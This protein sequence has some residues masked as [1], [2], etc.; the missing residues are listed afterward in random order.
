[1]VTKKKTPKKTAK[2]EPIKK[3]DNAIN[4]IDVVF[5]LDATGSM[6]PYIEEAKRMITDITNK[7]IRENPDL[8]IRV[9]LVL[10]RDHP[11]QEYSFVTQV[12][13]F[14]NPAEFDALIRPVFASGGGDHPE[15]V[16]DGVD[17]AFG[18]SWREGADRAA[19]LIG[20]APPHKQCLCGITPEALIE[21]LWEMS[22]EV[23]AHSI[24]NH[25]ATTEAFKLLTD[26]TGGNLTTGNQPKHTTELYESSL[27]YKS[28]M[29]KS[30]GA[31]RHVAMSESAGI[32]YT[33][34]AALSDSDISK[35]ADAAGMTL[36]SAKE[37]INYLKK[38][39]L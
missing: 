36:D 10:Y 19:Y 26:A 17:A 13:D 24:A 12:N 23:N 38:R 2:K 8:D 28:S 31:L 14:V 35:L 16:W 1:M 29:I 34:A 20:D 7:I 5:I 18:L 33:T 30:S 9:A 25:P 11:P 39:G 4:D 21:S 37:T 15:A 3:S 27:T 6:G 32:T 22:I